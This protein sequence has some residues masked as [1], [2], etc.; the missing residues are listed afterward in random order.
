MSSKEVLDRYEKINQ[1]LQGRAFYNIRSII[2]NSN[3]AEFFFLIGGAQ[4][5][6]SYSV[7]DFFLKQ[8]MDYGTPF[9]WIRLTEKQ[10]RQLLNNNA[11]KLID[12]DLRRKYNLDLVTNGINVYNVTKRSKPDK[13]GKTRIMEKKLLARVMALSTYYG[14][15][16]NGFFDKDYTGWYNIACDEFQPEKNER[17]TFDIVYAFVRQLENLVRNTKN[18]L[19][20]FLMANLLEE[21]SDI[22]CCFNFIPEK[23][24]RYKLKSKRAVIDYIEPS[25]A[26]KQMRK[27]SVADLLLPDASEYSNKI[28]TDY[29]LVYK[30]RLTSPLYVIKFSKDK[31]DWFSVWD[32][33]IIKKYNGEKKSVV[34][35]KPYL[36]EVYQVDLVNNIITI[37]DRRGF[38]YR[39]LITFKEFQKN[40]NLLKPRGN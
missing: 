11:E 17:R 30:G 40:I 3:W 20:V 23:F 21:A 31:S 29:T 16:G 22:L 12:P 27:G 39:D 7:T 5:G 18:H 32:S 15:K 38:K 19:R 6:K 14:D 34:A 4:A 2:G 28:E 25:D 13:K 37:F 1:V 36:D 10:S 9:Y 35:M 26:Y 8:F 24:G 33:N